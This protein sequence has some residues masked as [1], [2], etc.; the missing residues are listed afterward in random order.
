M[1]PTLVEIG[2]KR[3]IPS[4]ISDSLHLSTVSNSSESGWN[5]LTG[6]PFCSPFGNLKTHQPPTLVLLLVDN[7]EDVCHAVV[8]EGY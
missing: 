3:T 7:V 2:S 1:V 4:Y 6:D 8:F 5:R